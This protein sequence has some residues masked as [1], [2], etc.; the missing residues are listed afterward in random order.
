M[1]A[2]VEDPPRRDGERLAGQGHARAGTP[3]ARLAPFLVHTNHYSEL[4]TLHRTYTM[5]LGIV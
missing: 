5:V 3:I 2:L 4:R 1:T